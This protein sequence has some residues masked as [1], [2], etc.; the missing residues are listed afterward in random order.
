MMPHMEMEKEGK[1]KDF[2]V[3]VLKDGTLILSAGM[4]DEYAYDT[5]DELLDGLRSD[6]EGSTKKDEGEEDVRKKKVKTLME[7]KDDEE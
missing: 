4:G 6:L 1:P 3:R 7:E 2:H 5:V